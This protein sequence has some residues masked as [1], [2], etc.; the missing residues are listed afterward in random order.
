MR[1]ILCF[2]L[3][4]S[5]LILCAERRVEM[6]PYGE[7]DQWVVRYIQES[8]ILGGESKTLY[9]PAPSDTLRDNQIYIPIEG[10]PW[11]CSA[12]YAKFMGI[13]AGV[14]GSI[15]PETRGYGYCCKLK[16]VLTHV[17]VGDIYAMVSGT[18]YTG[19]AIEPMGL[20]AKSRPYTATEFGVPFTGHPIALM[21]DYKALISEVD[22]MLSTRKNKPEMVEG[23]D[24]AVV[25]AYLQYRW[26]D[27]ETGNIYARR[28][29]TAYERICKTIPEW[30]NNHE[31]PI[32]WGNITRDADYQ[33]YEGLNQ[34]EMMTRNSK[35]RMVRI[36]EVGWS[37][38]EPTHLVM[39]ISA[40]DAG[41]FRACEGNTLWVDNI[42]LVYKDDT[43]ITTK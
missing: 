3:A 15:V 37:L 35:G 33:D 25:Y 16:N 27:P 38:D 17:K 12:T 34:V 6:L 20:S 26:E 36:E 21:L 41:V 29:G 40:S 11:G 30:E 43:E 9:T 42:R 24:C 10:N 23:H 39:Y 8:K 1:I 2:C 4:L 18:L 14:E 32:R 5:S 7:L 22:S 28:V 19:Q 31:I 13:E